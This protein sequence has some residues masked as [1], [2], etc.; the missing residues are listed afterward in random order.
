MSGFVL[1]GIAADAAVARLR[2]GDAV[3]LLDVRK[4]AARAAS[5]VTLVDA[6]WRDPFALANDQSLLDDERETVCF[7]VHGH[8]VSQYACAFLMLHDRPASYVIGGMAA[9]TA[10]GA[11][12]AAI[13]GMGGER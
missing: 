10:A 6:M 7:C 8:E 9:L 3:R 11:P 12:M 1:P 13:D 5:G 4:A 2:S